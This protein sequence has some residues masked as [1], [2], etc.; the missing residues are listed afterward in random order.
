MCGIVVGLAFGKLS[1][2]DEAIRQ[3]ILRILTTEMLVL[4]EDRG[5][6]ATGA[7]LL[8]NDGNFTGMKRG[9]KASKF[10]AT[11]GESKDCYGG[12]LKI[13]KK[14]SEPARVYLGHCRAGTTGDKEDNENNHPIKIRNLV[15][16]HNGVIKNHEVIF[17]KLKCGRD[18]KVDSEAIFRLFEYYTNKGKEPFTMEMLQ[19]IVSRLEGQFAVTLFNADNLEQVPVFRDGR[20]VEFVLLRKYGILLMVSE[21]KFWHQAHFNYERIALYYNDILNTPLPSFLSAK[22]DDIV[23]KTLPDD[24]AMIFDLSMQVRSDTKIDDLGETK[25]ME[26]NEKIWQSKITTSIYTGGRSYGKDW[27]N[28]NKSTSTTK[29]TSAP[30]D[31]PKKRRVFDS[32]TNQY[33]IKVGD[34]ELSKE[35]AAVLPVDDTNEDNAEKNKKDSTTETKVIT[36]EKSDDKAKNAESE[37]KEETTS[38]KVEVDDKTH[39]DNTADVID[40]DPKDVKVLNPPDTKADVV[41]VDMPSFPPEIVEAALKAY[42][43]IPSKAKGCANEGEL[44]DILEIENKEKAESL[45]LGLV[46]NRAIKYGWMNGYMHAVQAISDLNL[47]DEKAKR[48]ERH[49]AGL[50]SLVVLLAA[51]YKAS[52]DETEEEDSPLN[53]IMRRRLAKAT[54]STDRNLDVEEISQVF[55]GYEKTVLKEVTEVVSRAGEIV[56]N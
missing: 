37:K 7:S 55:N 29:P 38:K 24:T 17:D 36:G 21:L 46:G 11:F 8:F 48:R 54:I 49:I 4:T 34:R 2:E 44:L 32:L 20:P 15:G 14:H 10:L 27:A 47:D 50:K 35:E 18:G 5:K 31:D 19:N 42:E 53:Y 3:I 41:E 16:I 26:R 6:D 45:G 13:W 39:Y 43:D 52:K 9:E 12:L 25:K 33:K 1:K 30:K 40:V 51:F 56:K 22:K 28:R 23:I